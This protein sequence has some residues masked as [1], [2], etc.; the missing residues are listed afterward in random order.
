MSHD[1]AVIGFASDA[2]AAAET[3][4]NGVRVV[5]LP[6]PRGGRSLRVG[7]FRIDSSAV[8]V[9]KILSR[10]TARF[11]REF[12][13]HVVES[14]DW[15]G[16][17]WTPPWRPLIVR[18]HG[19][20]SVLKPPGARKA[21]RL[22]RFLERRN[23][24]MADS[25]ASASRF[26]GRTTMDAL[27]IAKPFTTIYHGIDTDRFRPGEA[28]RCPKQV[29]FVGTV[30]KQKGIQELF[31]AIPRILEAAPEACFTIAGRY[32]ADPADPC[33]PQSLLR[34]LSR[35]QDSS[36]SSTRVRFLGQV[37]REGLPR[38]Y[39]RAAVAVFPSHFEAFGL[40]C[41]EAM[42]CGAAVI[43]TRS[44]SGPELVEAGVS[45]LLV[46]PGDSRAHASAV[47]R[48][49]NDPALRRR[50]AAEARRRIVENFRLEDTAARN[51]VFYEQAARRF[52]SPQNTYA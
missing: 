28:T 42:S 25:T 35:G 9:R 18:L 21:S 8:T 20:S 41:A 11:A 27:G 47:V 22:M 50:M 39:C 13:P 26:I 2:A 17:L 44:G 10:E 24:R 29:L 49:L 1:V 30:K 23:V 37:S 33:S 6:W 38:L 52:A 40:A 7:R 46:E 5:R 4:E 34:G 19:A 31:E 16:P 51:I 3:V 32:P 48:L 45:G 36:F 12:R 15:S 43:F 14:H